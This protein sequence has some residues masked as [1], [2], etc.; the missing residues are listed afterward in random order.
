MKQ[1]KI[2]AYN[3]QDLDD[4]GKVNVKIW[5]DLIPDEVEIEDE[6][7]N[8]IKRTLSYPSDWEE[9]K[10]EDHCEANEYL[11]SKFGECIHHLE[12]REE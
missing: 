1:M 9:E 6:N 12:I 5:L 4:K 2:D 7:G 8:I 3:Y 10:I 11:F